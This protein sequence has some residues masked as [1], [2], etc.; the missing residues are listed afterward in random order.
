MLCMVRV[1]TATTDEKTEHETYAQ[2]RDNDTHIMEVFNWI[3]PVT[4]LGYY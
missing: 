1:K 2:K 3:Q 4:S